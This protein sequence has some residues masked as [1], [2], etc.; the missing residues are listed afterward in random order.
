MLRSDP[1]RGSAVRLP[2]HRLLA[3]GAVVS[4]AFEPIVA[5]LSYIRARGSAPEDDILYALTAREEEHHERLGEDTYDGID[6]PRLLFDLVQ[7]GR[8][9]WR[10][11]PGGDGGGTKPLIYSLSRR[12]AAIV[13]RPGVERRVVKHEPLR[14]RVRFYDSMTA[15]SARAL[16]DWYQSRADRAQPARLNPILTNGQAIEILRDGIAAVADDD[17]IRPIIARHVLK[18][19]GWS[20]AFVWCDRCK[21]RGHRRNSRLCIEGSVAKTLAEDGRSA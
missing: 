14:G 2:V 11:P 5:V 17:P 8:L 10:D 3:G 15:R 1:L 6:G 4:A 7:A 13:D 12:E 21:V 16:L 9:R 18:L 19:V 20:S